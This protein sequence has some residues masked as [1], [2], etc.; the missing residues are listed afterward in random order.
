MKLFNL[1]SGVMNTCFVQNPQGRQEDV[2]PEKGGIGGI[3]LR[4]KRRNKLTEKLK[5]RL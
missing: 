1:K 5:G 4:I 3:P 2:S